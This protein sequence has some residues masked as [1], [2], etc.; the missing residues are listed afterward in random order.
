M[1]KY[2]LLI[3]IIIL[4]ACGSKKDLAELRENRPSWAKS[5]PV[6]AGYYTGVGMAPKTLSADKHQQ[7][8]RNQALK[9]IAEEISVTISSSSLLRN[10]EMDDTFVSD[11]SS[12]ISTSSNHDLEGYEL[13]DTYEDE[14]YYFAFYKLSKA[15]FEQIRQDRI[16]NAVDKATGYAETFH[17]Q[18]EQNNFSEAFIALVQGLEIIRPHMHEALP[19]E[20]NNRQVDM[21]NYLV[22]EM[23]AMF[24]DISI[25]PMQEKISIIRGQGIDEKSLTFRVRFSEGNPV[26]NFPLQ[27][28]FSAQTIVN[29]WEI[30][31]DDGYAGFSVNKVISKSRKGTF[32]VHADVESLLKR[33]TSDLLVRNIVRKMSVPG[34]DM[35]VEI[36]K[37]VFFIDNTAFDDLNHSDILK[38]TM[39]EKIHSHDFSTTDNPEKAHYIAEIKGQAQV[40]TSRYESKIALLSIEY[41]I[42]DENDNVIFSTRSEDFQGVNADESRAFK[43]AFSQAEEELD[44]RIFDDFYYHH[45]R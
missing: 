1:K 37:P 40:T 7:V 30:T 33:T 3:F 28:A 34:A 44:N 39:A 12:D 24:N 22:E 6:V 21:G 23:R 27:A 11:Y 45:F 36:I 15:K 5:K 43:K 41:Q 42:T 25:T 14:E 17:S 4:S 10:L 35:E 2:S 26:K 32:R 13:V 16:T 20:V 29:S 38:N 18:K 31:D 19:A 8:A 9:D